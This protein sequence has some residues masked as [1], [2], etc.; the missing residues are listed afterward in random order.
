MTVKVLSENISFID[1]PQNIKVK[2]KSSG[3]VVKTIKQIIYTVGLFYDYLPFPISTNHRMD[4]YF[5]GEDDS[6]VL[7]KKYEAPIIRVP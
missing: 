6:E 5:I 4:V 7:A 3:L 1:L 2:L